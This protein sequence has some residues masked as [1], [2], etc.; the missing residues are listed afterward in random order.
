MALQQVSNA[1]GVRDIPVTAEMLAASQTAQ[2]A[3]A[4]SAVR[5]AG[6][7]AAA[8]PS[9]AAVPAQMQPLSGRSSMRMLSISARHS[10]LGF[11]LGHGRPEHSTAA[12]V[13]C[14]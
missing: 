13:P 5:S 4:R 8:C 6:A 7:Q 12:L 11:V 1:Y 2:A 10:T 9:Q 14:C 3:A